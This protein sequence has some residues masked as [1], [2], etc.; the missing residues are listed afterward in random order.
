MDVKSAKKPFVAISSRLTP[1][2][3]KM[4]GLLIIIIIIIIIIVII[5]IIIVI[6]ISTC[7]L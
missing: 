3:A 6:I 1:F 4:P 7:S 2:F 5:I